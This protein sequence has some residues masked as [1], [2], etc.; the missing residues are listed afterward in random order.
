[1]LYTLNMLEREV[2][3]MEKLEA[4]FYIEKCNLCKKYLFQG[5]GIYILGQVICSECE[6]GFAHSVVASYDYDRQIARMKKIIF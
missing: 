3:S 2:I 6:K 5:M 1:M 4:K